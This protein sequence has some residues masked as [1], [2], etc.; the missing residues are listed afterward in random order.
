MHNCFLG[1]Q[2]A[3]LQ[4]SLPTL[5]PSLPELLWLSSMSRG[6]GY[7]FGQW[8]SAVLSL[9][10]PASRAARETEIFLFYCLPGSTTA[11][12]SVCS[13]HYSYPKSKTEHHMRG[14]FEENKCIPAKTM[15]V[16]I[17]SG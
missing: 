3:S 8:G 10:P 12:A 2:T 15:T 6:V 9:S 13:Q 5:S 16:F 7:P 4:T 11:K 1:R 14:I 17:S